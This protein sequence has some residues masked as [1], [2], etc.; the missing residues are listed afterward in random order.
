MAE[1]K[2]EVNAA[3]RISTNAASQL[4]QTYKWPKFLQWELAEA[5]SNT[6]SPRIATVL[7][8]GNAAP[9]VMQQQALMRQMQ[10]SVAAH[11]SQIASLEGGRRILQ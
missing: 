7:G 8:R 1:L 11:T 5:D 6:S 2:L 4:P 3:Q 10:E 9:S